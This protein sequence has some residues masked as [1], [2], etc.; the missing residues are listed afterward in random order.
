VAYFVGDKAPS[1]QLFELRRLHSPEHGPL[2]SWTTRGEWRRCGHDELVGDR[3]RYRLIDREA[4][5]KLLGPALKGEFDE[6]Y[7][8]EVAEAIATWRLQ[9]EPWWTE[10]IVVGNEE[11]V[12]KAQTR[13]R[14]RLDT[15]EAASGVWVVRECAEMCRVR[16][17]SLERE[18]NLE[19][20]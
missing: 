7:R 8:R 6:A 18:N 20:R 1:P 14:R 5:A 4:L 15:G 12:I 3:T 9:R 11:F 17:L 19:N 13:Y 10:S 2:E 16:P